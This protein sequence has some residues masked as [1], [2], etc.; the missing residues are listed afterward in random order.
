MFFTVLY[1]PYE[2]HLREA[3]AFRQHPNF[4][5]VFYEDLKEDFMK[6]L[7]RLDK[8]IGTDLTEQQML[9]VSW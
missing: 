7:K 2:A 9:N 6:E 1:G 4:H 5:M 3:A 8:F